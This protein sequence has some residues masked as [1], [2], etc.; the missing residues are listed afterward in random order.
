MPMKPSMVVHAHELR[1]LRQEDLEFEA[2][3]GCTVR[4]Y[5]IK[6]TNKQTKILLADQTE[7][8]FGCMGRC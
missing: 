4:P 3:L 5:L 8:F 1:M 6:Q 7:R 2:S